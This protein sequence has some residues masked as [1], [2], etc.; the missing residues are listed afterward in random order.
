MAAI[1][2]DLIAKNFSNDTAECEASLL[3]FGWDFLSVLHLYRFSD[4]LNHP[5][6]E[7]IWPFLSVDYVWEY[8]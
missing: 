4:A 7:S 1:L 6:G 3:C 2:V 8:V 5:F